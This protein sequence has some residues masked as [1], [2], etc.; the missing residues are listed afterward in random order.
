MNLTGSTLAL[1]EA[2][3]PL[4]RHQ[5][6]GTVPYNIIMSRTDICQDSISYDHVTTATYDV[7]PKLQLHNVMNC[8]GQEA[9][10]CI[11]QVKSHESEQ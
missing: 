3:L 10:R 8:S 7:I 6:C 11:A 9:E 5:P 2:H 4:L 1:H